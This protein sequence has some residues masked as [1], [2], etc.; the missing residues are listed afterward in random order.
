MVA[1]KKTSQTKAAPPS[2]SVR[3]DPTDHAALL[4]AA[5]CAG[6]RPGGL[7]RVLVSFALQELGKGNSHLDRAIKVSRD[8]PSQPGG[9]SSVGAGPA[10]VP[11]R[12][13][14]VSRDRPFPR[15]PVVRLTNK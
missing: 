3:L 7:A 8:A 12:A 14:K 10:T 15:R 6:M 9:A 13:I 11:D 2:V 1:T 4:A 5:A